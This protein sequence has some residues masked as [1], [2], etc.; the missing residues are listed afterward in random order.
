[1]AGQLAAVGGQRQLVERAC[2]QVAAEALEQAD[3]V[4]PHQRFAAG[5][6]QLANPLAYESAAQPVQLFQAEDVLLRQER[7]L[8][9]H[10]VNA[11]EVAPVR[12]RNPE[13]GDR[14]TKRIDHRRSPGG[15]TD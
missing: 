13:V 9:G 14:A 12:D 4:A 15:P 6:A 10:A 11:A 7:H 1:M 5:E 3:H 2:A 8:L